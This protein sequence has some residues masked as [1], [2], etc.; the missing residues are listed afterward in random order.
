M[1]SCEQKTKVIRD[2]PQYI[3]PMWSK[4]QG[5]LYTIKMSKI[6]MIHLRVVKTHVFEMYMCISAVVDTRIK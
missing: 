5:Q 6:N 4:R 1:T 2:S 3:G